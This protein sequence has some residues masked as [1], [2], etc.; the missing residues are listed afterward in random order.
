MRACTHARM[1]ACTHRSS[2]INIGCAMRPCAHAPMRPHPLRR[3]CTCL[4]ATVDTNACG[5]MHVSF[6]H[7]C[8]H[9][10]IYAYMHAKRIDV[11]CACYYACD[12]TCA[13]ACACAPCPCPCALCARLLVRTCRAQAQV[14]SGALK[15]AHV[16]SGACKPVR[17]AI[18]HIR[19]RTCTET[20]RAYA[21]MTTTM[22]T[23]TRANARM[24]ACTLARTGPH[25]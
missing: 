9:V 24:H 10:Y 6:W 22:T 17:E 8:M 12:G 20:S 14:R 25:G 11:R 2:W 3:P 1:H 23:V 15:S 13:F 21:P 5:G 16:Q 18:G 7:T 4:N 19:A